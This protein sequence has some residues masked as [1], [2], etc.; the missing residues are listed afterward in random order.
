MFRM[1]TRT[2]STSTP[3]KKTRKCSWSDFKQYFP[4]AQQS[5]LQWTDKIANLVNVTTMEK[6]VTP[7]ASP[8]NHS[9][10]EAPHPGLADDCPVAISSAANTAVR[11]EGPYF[12]SVNPAKYSCT[13][14]LVAGTGISGAI[15]IAGA[16]AERQR[17]RAEV[18]TDSSSSTATQTRARPGGFGWQRCIIVWTVREEDHIDLPLL[19]GSGRSFGDGLELRTHLT[20]EGRPRLD[21]KATIQN[22]MREAGI[23]EEIGGTKMMRRQKQ[24]WVYIS[25]PDG[26]VTTAETA[27]KA[28]YL[29]SYEA[30]Q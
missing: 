16:F 14:C 30:K 10:C 21:A 22:I 20:G 17:T 9:G 3:S 23:S 11:L 29:D 19:N 2:G 5:K 25:G 13:I 18:T 28:L 24:V 1:S 8:L 27:C 4:R 15:A 7:L 12:T 26:F 6:V